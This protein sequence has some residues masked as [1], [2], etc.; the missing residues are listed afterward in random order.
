MNMSD[1]TIETTEAIERIAGFRAEGRT[2]RTTNEG[3]ASARDQGA[4]WESLMREGFLF[5]LLEASG[6]G[7]IWGIYS[8]YERDWMKPYDFTLA[9]RKASHASAGHEGLTVIDVPSGEYAVF[10][11]TSANPQ[12]AS[13]SVWKSVWSWSAANPG[14]RAYGIDFERWSAAELASGGTV[15]VVVYISVKEEK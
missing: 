13:L 12:S 14:R 9:A 2:I 5:P 7:A 6:D 8:N 15:S 4:L 11:A 3:G 1:G 10:R